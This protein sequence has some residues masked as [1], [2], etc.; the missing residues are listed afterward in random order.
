M[1][2]PELLQTGQNHT[3]QVE[4]KNFGSSTE[5]F[6][7]QFEIFDSLGVQIYNS[8]TNVSN[9]APN[10]TAQPTFSP[11]W[12]VSQQ[13]WY[14]ARA[15]AQLTGDQFRGND[16]L[17]QLM[18]CYHDV[19]VTGITAPFSEITINYPMAPAAVAVNLGSY[20]EDFPVVCQIRDSASSLVFAD[21][22]Q[23]SGL[24]PYG[25]I[26][27]N[28]ARSWSPGRIG[29]YT[30]AVFSV[31]PGDYRPGNDRATAPSLCTYEIIYDDAGAEAYYWVG[32]HDND[33]FYV[34]FSPT[35][36]PP[37]SLKRGRIMVNMANTPFD[38][39]L[40]V[41][42]S[43][44]VPDTANSLQRVD[45]VTSPQAPGWATF[46]L[47]VN[48]YDANDVWLVLHWPDGSP[49]MGV[50]SDANQPRDLRSYWSSNQDPFTQWQNHDWMV[51]LLQ[52]PN[53]GIAEN[54]IAPLPLGIQPPHPNPF[55]L[56]TTIEFLVATRSR[57]SLTVY[58]ALGQCVRVLHRGRAEPGTSRVTWDG[59]NDSDQRLPSGVYF[60]QLDAGDNRLVRKVVLQ[61]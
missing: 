22:A 53:V 9:L 14:T 3:P 15:T 49:A 6:P 48:R 57:I 51:R 44:G 27:V 47:D 29:R 61:R 56:T 19:G 38:Y 10:A 50:G 40:L 32:R 34:R 23:V 60:L 45:N 36:S 8:T 43:S 18:R 11:A 52:D 28:F 42:D 59:R 58:N 41:P 25:Q 46:D 7:I 24:A 26:A 54:N 39:V 2:P 16:T 13:G 12:T 17:V 55:V 4:V 30:V 5:T 35:I 20:T 21:T 31:L 1:S 33:K 37:L